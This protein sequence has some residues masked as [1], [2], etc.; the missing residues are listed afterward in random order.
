MPADNQNIVHKAGDSL[1]IV[2][3]VKDQVGAAIP[4]AGATVRWWIGMT[5]FATGDQIMV[6]KS[7]L[8]QGVAVAD[9]VA[10]ISLLP[11]DTDSMASGTYYHEAEVAFADG[12]VATVTTGAFIIEPTIIR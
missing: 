2:L 8:G 3:P 11:A 10:T 4:L 7:S 1:Q 12:S 5:K 6:K 9:A